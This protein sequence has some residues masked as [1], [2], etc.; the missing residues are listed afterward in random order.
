MADVDK[1]IT[2]KVRAEDDTQKATQSAKA[3]LRDLQK[4]ML[5]LEAAGQKNTDQF[6]KMAAEAGSLKDAIGDTSAQVKALASDT[7]TLDTFTS[8]IQGIAGGFAVAQGA[9][10][11][12]G[13][14]SEDV[15]KAMMK[16]QAALALVNGATAVAN[17]L[18][19]DSALMVN[20]NAAA[21]RAYA[22]AVGT[23]TGAL[24]A[25]R[26]ALVTTGIGAVVVALG[27]AIEAMIRFTSK[28]DDQNEAQKD[29]NKSLF[30]SV[31]MLDLYE[32]KLKAEGATD[33]QIAKIR[34]ARFERDLQTSLSFLAVLRVQMKEN[35]TQAQRDLELQYMQEIQLLKVKIAEENRILQD[36]RAAR[37]LQAKADF[38]KRKKENEMEYRAEQITLQ[39]HL[40]KMLATT[41]SNEDVKLQKR[42]TSIKYQL[43][44][45]RRMQQEEERLEQMKIDTA[46]KTFQTLGNLSTLFAGKSERSQRRAFEINKKM[47]MAQTLIETFSAAQG[48][49]RS[50][51]VI[52]DPSAPVRA[53]IA[54][55][56]AV[57][58]GLLRVQQ[59]SKQTFQS[60]SAVTGGGGGGGS[61]PP[62]TGGF[63]SGG[64]VMNPNSQ[65]TNPN[66]GAGA[67]QGQSMRA[68]VVESDVRTVSGRLRR[69]SE[70]AQL[71]N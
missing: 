55:A 31:N 5:D 61:A 49:Y 64:G 39:E 35:S 48:A 32:R 51:M 27:F 14:E 21:Q 37:A 59:I 38:E 16:V 46:A 6:R 15:Q 30:E 62:T 29:L 12:F 47:S 69:I 11:L 68:Y 70:F 65:L 20:L 60:P 34:M 63:A 23:S 71:A 28:T 50:Q 58:A 56:A 36:A 7:R 42:G 33:E 4:Q 10:A 1:E 18:N 2:V 57:A 43:D 17:A 8:A 41:R 25:F 26:I 22:L 9:A 45:Q 67:G 54:A 52:P 53:T 44:L 19:K 40:D 13:E 66:E 24:K 3:R